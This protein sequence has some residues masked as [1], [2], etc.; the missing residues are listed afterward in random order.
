MCDSKE[1]IV[2]YVYDELSPAEQQGLEAHLAA[3]AECRHELEGL[4]ATR[5]H[6]GLWSPPEPDLGLRIVRGASEPAPALPRRLR[7]APAFAYAAAAAI[8]LAV[9]AAIANVEVR[10]APD[11]VVVRTGWART[12]IA[13]GDG[14]RDPGTPA[15]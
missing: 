8:V 3:C 12:E 2:G 15:P 14:P 1:L 13:G 5:V 9:S 6:L 10:Y 7:L 4:R 11:G